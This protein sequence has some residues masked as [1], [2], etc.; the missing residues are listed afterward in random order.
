MAPDLPTPSGGLRVI[1]DL[2][3][4]AR[5]SGLAAHV[6]HGTPGHRLPDLDG[7]CD[8]ITG[9]QLRAEAGDLLVMPEVGGSKWSFL[10][11]GA[12]VVMLVQGIDFVFADATFDT[13]V[14][15]AYPGWPSARAAIATSESIATFLGRACQPTFP[16]HRLPVDVDAEVFRPAVKER[17][18][19][20][21]PRRRREDLLAVVQLLRRQDAL[22][23]WEIVLIDG[24]SRAQVAATM[25]RC[26][27]FLSGAEREGF[28]LPGAEAMAAGCH[29][30]GFTGDG[31]KEYMLPGLAS[32]ATESDVV[33]MAD[34]VQAAMLEFDADPD[35]F[36]SRS[37]RGR[38]LIVERYAPSINRGR[39]EEAFRALTEP[40]SPALI[41]VPTTLRHYQIHAPRRGLLPSGYRAARRTARRAVDR[42]GGSR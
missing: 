23:D 6:W 33:G 38:A 3:G 14:P 26:A 30:V 19:A 2:A 39:V 37:A 1:Y 31:A 15:E 5:R 16:I 29:V 22:G 21:M 8:V 18:I 40:S 28:G 10:P 13:A 7:K 4:H 27:I 34:L 41:T 12:P 25:G 35:A 36:A 9:P 20:L 32:V 24:M 17:L 42:W 11:A